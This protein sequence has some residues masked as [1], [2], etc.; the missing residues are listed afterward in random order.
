[1]A[2]LKTVARRTV[3]LLLGLLLLV[4]ALYLILLVINWQDAEPNADSLHMQSLLQQDAI[5]AEQNG[6][7]YYLAHNAKNELLLSGPLEEL[8]RQCGE[9]EACT[10]SLNAQT[11]LAE[12]IAEHTCLSGTIAWPAVIFMAS[13]AGGEKR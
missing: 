3:K 12:L 7:H 4:T 1:M 5:P 11:D 9:V 13:L 6:Y 2:V 8:Y 10:A